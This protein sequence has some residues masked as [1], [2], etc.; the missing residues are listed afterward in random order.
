MELR[1]GNKYRL[2]RKIGSGSFGDI[3]LGKEFTPENGVESFSIRTM[4]LLSSFWFICFR[5][6]V[7][8]YNWVMFYRFP[9]IINIDEKRTSVFGRNSKFQWQTF[10][11][12]WNDS[13]DVVLLKFINNTHTL[14][15]VIFT[16]LS[17]NAGQWVH[18]L[19]LNDVEISY[20]IEHLHCLYCTRQLWREQLLAWLYLFCKGMFTVLILKFWF[21]RPS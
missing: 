11:P 7:I 4:G 19:S 17:K 18:S 12:V 21:N 10:Q 20:C 1:V 9:G 3:Y 15:A 2:G 13:L 5:F 6:H 8:L 16:E 14:T